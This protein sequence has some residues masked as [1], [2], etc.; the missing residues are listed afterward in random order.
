MVV[1][2]ASLQVSEKL[3]Y[4]SSILS[5]NALKP[6]QLNHRTCSVWARCGAVSEVWRGPTVLCAESGS[7]LLSS[8]PKTVECL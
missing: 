7:G 8:H 2:E 4:T 5:I 6:Y 3:I 1:A